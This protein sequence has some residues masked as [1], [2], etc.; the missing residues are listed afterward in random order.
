MRS[1]KPWCSA[2]ALLATL[3]FVNVTFAQPVNIGDF[4]TPA[5]DAWGTD[6]GPGSPVLSQAT[7]GVTRNNFSLRATNP[8]GGF[9]GPATGNLITNHRLDLQNANTVSFDLTMIGTELN[10]G[11]PFAGFAQANELAVTLFSPAGGSNLNLFIQ[12]NAFAGGLQD[13]RGHAGQWSGDD[14]T[15]TLTWNLLNFTA[16]DPHDNQLKTVRQFLQQYP[17]IVD[18]KIAFTEQIGGGTSATGNM[19]W[20]NVNLNVIPEPATLG[21]LALALPVLAMRRRHA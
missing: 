8:Q 18:A 12:K 13:S 5:L 2:L 7:I 17:D 14:G 1:F 15:R 4:E 3:A 19:Y 16:T 11:Q 10:G 20:D 6:G 9:W 21:L